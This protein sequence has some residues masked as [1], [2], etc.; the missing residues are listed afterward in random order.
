MKKYKNIN[1]LKDEIA[2][3]LNQRTGY[4][5]SIAESSY[6]DETFNMRIYH[7]LASKDRLIIRSG[8]G[9]SRREVLEN[10]ITT[11]KCNNAISLSLQLAS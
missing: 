2:D 9:Y 6:I 5:W 7:V 8:E 4:T 11:L 1:D 10:M 3:I